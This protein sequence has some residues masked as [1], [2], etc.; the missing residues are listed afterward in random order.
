MESSQG[1]FCADLHGADVDPLLP[2]TPGRREDADISR[3]ADAGG[4]G[5]ARGLHGVNGDGDD[6]PHARLRVRLHGLFVGAN[7]CYPVS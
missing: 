1:H 4:G 5:A 3:A 2:R 6:L 7:S